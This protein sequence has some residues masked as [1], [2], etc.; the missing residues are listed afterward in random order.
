MTNQEGIQS[1]PLRPKRICLILLFVLTGEWF[2]IS[3]MVTPPLFHKLPEI[4]R[5][6]REEGRPMSS[7]TVRFVEL[8]LI[9]YK[10][11]LFLFLATLV[12]GGA[13]H[14]G[15]SGSWIKWIN[16]SLATMIFLTAAFTAAGLYPVIRYFL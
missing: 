16:L 6:L 13:T 7:M 5:A 8:G 2:V 1:N 3:W 10:W 14:W 4:S 15:L 9:V 12:A 11:T